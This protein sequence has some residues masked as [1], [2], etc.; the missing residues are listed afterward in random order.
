MAQEA[1]SNRPSINAWQVEHLRLSSFPV[2][3]SQDSESDWWNDVTG[4]EPETKVSEPRKGR[5]QHKGVLEDNKALKLT[6][7]P[8]RIDWLLSMSEDQNDIPPDFP[9]I[10]PFPDLLDTFSRL[11][12]RWFELQT[13]PSVVRMAFG[14]VLLLPAESKVA[15]YQ[16]IAEYLPFVQLEPEETSD[17]LY[18]INRPRASTSNIPELEINRLSKWNVATLRRF[19]LMLG[20]TVIRNRPLSQEDHACRLQMDI[21]TSQYFSGEIAREQLP[22]IFQEL[23]DLGIEIV[24][25]G[26]TP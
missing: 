12:R 18:Q 15:G 23:V 24:N 11:M 25:R 21:N 6:V 14:A 4:R 16:Q 17:F 9:T 13:C 1:R 26:D 3:A 10:G 2:P 5:W 22:E 19:G 20:P 8:G 7:E